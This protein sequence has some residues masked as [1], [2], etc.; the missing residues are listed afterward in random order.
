MRIYLTNFAA[1][2]AMDNLKASEQTLATI[3]PGRRLSIQR[4]PRDYEI[5]QGRVLPLVP[6]R[7]YVIPAIRAKKKHDTYT[8][9]SLDTPPQFGDQAALAWQ[10]YEEALRG[11]WERPEHM[12]RL[13]PGVLSY[14]LEAWPNE[15]G[16]RPWDGEWWRRGRLVEDG[17]TLYCSCSKADAEAGRCHRVIA[18]DLLHQA[19]WEVILGGR[20]WPRA[21]A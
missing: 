3:G 16:A 21:T 4:Y 1:L 8:G 11:L 5:G 18:A 14:A 15:E 20:E 9:R 7:S 12:A 2:A 6:P 19:G 17:D 13:A 10:R